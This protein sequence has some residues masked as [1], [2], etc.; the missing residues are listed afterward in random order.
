[1]TADEYRDLYHK[2]EQEYRA[3]LNAVTSE[4]YA[5]ITGGPYF[6]LVPQIALYSRRVI[7]AQRKLDHELDRIDTVWCE[8]FP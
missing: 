4:L 7:D 2:A 5:Q 1:M 8:Q 6:A 3:V